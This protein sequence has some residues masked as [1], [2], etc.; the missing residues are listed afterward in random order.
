MRK[1]GKIDY[2][3]LHCAATPPS[4]DVGVKEIRRWHTDEK[5]KGN[6]WADIGYHFVI[7]R[8]GHVQVGRP[9]IWQGAHVYGYNRNSIAICLVG[10][11]A[12]NGRSE[13]N[14][15]RFQK[16]AAFKLVQTLLYKHQSA[17]LMGHRDFPGVRKECPSFDVHAWFRGPQ[18]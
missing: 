6:G 2:I 5:P 13:D 3:V 1:L 11:S 15:T 18:S 7:K 16:D 10:G 12:E 14:F 8:N 4:M 17:R 9:L